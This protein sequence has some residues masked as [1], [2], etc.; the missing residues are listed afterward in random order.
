M[1]DE[2][3]LILFQAIVE[4]VESSESSSEEEEEIV[5]NFLMNTRG[6]NI[7]RGNHFILAANDFTDQEFKSHFR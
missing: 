4:A 3:R 6:P 1:D 2:N 7:D 5:F